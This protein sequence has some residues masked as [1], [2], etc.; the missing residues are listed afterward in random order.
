MKAHIVAI[1]DAAVQVADTWSPGLP[2]LRVILT[3]NFVARRWN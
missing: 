1:D 2:P 3:A